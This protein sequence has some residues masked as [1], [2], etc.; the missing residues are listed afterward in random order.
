[1]PSRVAIVIVF[2]A[3]LGIIAWGVLGFDVTSLNAGAV[4]DRIRGAGM[5]GHLS[6]FALLILQCVISPL[7]SEPLMMAAGYLYGPRPGFVLAWTGVTCGAM[8]CF[9]LAQSVGAPLVHRF[10]EPK[11]I[12]ALE[13][14]FANRSVLAAASLLL[15]IRIFAFSSFDLVSYACGLLR[16]PVRWFFVTSALGVTPKVF[17]FTYL[18]AN[19]GPQ[20]VWLNVLIAVGMLGILAAIPLFMRHL[21][22]QA[23]RMPEV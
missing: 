10:V 4:A 13:A 22:R 15:F 16:F 14:Y 23:R 8:A 12:T 5:V 19:V 6:L 7:P 1:M 17:A 21:A 11:R 3:L 20:P 9:A 2:T 18:G